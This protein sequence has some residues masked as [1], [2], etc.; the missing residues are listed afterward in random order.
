M[1]SSLREQ[2]LLSLTLNQAYRVVRR[3][4]VPLR[5]LLTGLKSD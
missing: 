4:P 3:A 2:R 5:V 1:R